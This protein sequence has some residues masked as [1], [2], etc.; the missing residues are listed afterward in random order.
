MALTA[1]ETNAL[2]AFVAENVAPLPEGAVTHLHKCGWWVTRNEG[3]CDSITEFALNGGTIETY[4]WRKGRRT[5]RVVY[6]HGGGLTCRGACA[7]LEEWLESR[8]WVFVSKKTQPW[9]PRKKR[10][11]Y[12]D[13]QYRYSNPPRWADVK[14]YAQI[15]HE[16]S[17]YVR[18]AH[19]SYKFWEATD[20][21]SWVIW[22][23]DMKARGRKP[24]VQR[25]LADLIRTHLPDE[26]QHQPVYQMVDELVRFWTPVPSE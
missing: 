4:K 26:E 16:I 17:N 1:R 23:A 13:V 3:G 19:D 9:P 22:L 20:I 10:S 21:A 8:G 11:L 12:Y 18:A 6:R 14:M 25:I 24:R 5:F 7:A 2:E 15:A